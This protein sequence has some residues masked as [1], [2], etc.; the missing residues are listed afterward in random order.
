MNQESYGLMTQPVKQQLPA[1]LFDNTDEM[2][3]PKQKF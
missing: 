1:F 3:V 2:K